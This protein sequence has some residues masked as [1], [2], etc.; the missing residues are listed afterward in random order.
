MAAPNK[1]RIVTKILS[2]LGKVYD[3]SLPEDLTVLDHLLLGVLQEE[4]SLPI[5]V[6]AY[7]NLRQGFFD[8]NEMRVSHPSEVVDYL[9]EVPNK[10]NKA[11]RVLDIL[12][13][14]FETTY[15]FDLESM[16]RKPLKQAQKQLSKIT[17]T[18]DFTVAATV[19]RALG[20][21][22]MPIDNAICTMLARLDLIDEGAEPQEIRGAVEH[23]VPKAKGVSFCLL[24]SAL[25][26][27]EEKREEVI[28]AILPKGKK[29]PEKEPTASEP[30][31]Q[32]PK[33]RSVRTSNSETPPPK[34]KQ[35][36]SKAK[37]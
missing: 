16:R 29:K 4:T 19:Q 8:F 23:L 26:A 2:H 27:D 7:Q 35:S 22:A 32:S 31:A 1:Q 15:S 28:S 30:E 12:Q 18:S 36:T 25:A 5:A 34:T 37:K 10:E 21:H 24:I 13:F 14:V 17:G 11:R 6:N 9:Q 3:D 33:K 20:G